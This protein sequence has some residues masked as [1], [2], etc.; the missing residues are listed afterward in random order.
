MFERDIQIRIA[1]ALESMASA[2]LRRADVLETS[3]EMDK[4]LVERREAAIETLK[5]TIID[6]S[7]GEADGPADFFEDADGDSL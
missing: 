6:R 1:L 5:N 2:A 3:L 7:K 4:E